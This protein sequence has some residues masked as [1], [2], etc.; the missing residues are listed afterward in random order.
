M[1]VSSRVVFVV[2]LS[3]SRGLFFSGK[4]YV[5]SVGWW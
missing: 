4:C 2:I 3:S 5:G 1:M